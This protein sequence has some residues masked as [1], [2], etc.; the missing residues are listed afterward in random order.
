MDKTVIAI[1]LRLSNED[2]NKGQSEESNSIF[3]QRQL[4]T[5]HIQEL[6]LG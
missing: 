2:K 4:I 3:A 1:Y 6:M 5:A